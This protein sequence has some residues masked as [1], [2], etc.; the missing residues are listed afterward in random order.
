MAD[1]SVLPRSRR[2]KWLDANPEKMKAARKKWRDSH[3]DKEHEM[4]RRYRERNAEKVKET[5][6]RFRER[7]RER[8]LEESR[9]AY[10]SNP[11][12]ARK[13][14]RDWYAANKERVRES[15]RSRKYG[16][17]P[18]EIAEMRVRQGGRCAA[19]GLHEGELPPTHDRAPKTLDVDHD[20]VTGA[21]RGLL[22]HGC[23]LALGNAGE[24]PERL[25]LLADYIERTRCRI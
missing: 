6:R 10:A 11:D 4:Q 22:C 9:L 1:L 18:E 12:R 15:V 25:R 23:N 3:P 7:H 2:Q 19:C 13:T 17:A 8:L 16:I 21:V 24:S 14:S 5:K 20:H